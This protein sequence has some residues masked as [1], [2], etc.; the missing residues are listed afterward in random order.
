MASS[1]ELTKYVIKN[2][3]NMEIEV[4]NLGGVISKVLVPDKQNNQV[5][6]VLGFQDFED[7]RSNPPYFGCIVGRYGNRIAGSSFN[8]DHHNYPLTP[9]LG[10]HNLHGGIQGFHKHFWTVKKINNGLELSRPSPHLEEGF[11]GNLDVTV[12]YILTDQNQ[13]II[14]YLATTDKP[15]HVN[16][17][18]HS[19][20]NLNGAG[21]H[22]IKNHQIKIDA[23][24]IT[25][26]D[27]ELIPTGDFLHVA[28]TPF[29]LRASILLEEAMS[30][31][32]PYFAHTGSFDHN[33]VIQEEAGSLKE[34]AQVSSDLTGIQMRVLTTEPGI[35]LY[36]GDFDHGQF[37][38]KH[39]QPYLGRAAFCLETQHHPDSP[40]QPH[41]PST[42]LRPGEV[43]KSQTIYAFN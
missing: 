9:N 40:N 36:C 14:N 4:L 20:F 32:H 31:Q 33:W 26:V 15:T 1:T 39:G 2:N 38:G 42:V 30:K 27:A 41:F 34:V 37:L 8:L 24:Y 18:N 17:T 43:Y 19:Y 29:D 28:H 7:Y 12:Q 16:L 11:P 3:A 13:L 6:V 25:A 10:P 21:G 35:Q 5:D 22:D 23:D